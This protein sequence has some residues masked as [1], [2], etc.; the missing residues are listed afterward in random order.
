MFPSVNVDICMARS[1]SGSLFGNNIW[2]C[3]QGFFSFVP[4]HFPRRPFGHIMTPPMHFLPLI[5]FF[6][7]WSLN[8]TPF[9]PESL[10]IF[11]DKKQVRFTNAEKSG[12]YWIT[13]PL[14][15]TSIVLILTPWGVNHPIKWTNSQPP[16]FVTC[17]VTNTG[18]K[19]WL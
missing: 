9:V 14:L 5:T 16:S 10:L 11:Y 1:H 7:T 2:V 4:S 6:H 12:I 17:H 3:P 15:N 13:H 18:L 19:T 8:Y